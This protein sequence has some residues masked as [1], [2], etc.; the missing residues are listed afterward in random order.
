MIDGKLQRL[1]C[2]THDIP[3]A[4]AAHFALQILY[5]GTACLAT[6]ALNNMAALKNA[7][8]FP[9][10][11]V[12]RTRLCFTDHASLPRQQLEQS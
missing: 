11:V 4:C 1:L 12:F 3:L 10:E 2:L 5:T 8:N 9:L 6:R 7:L